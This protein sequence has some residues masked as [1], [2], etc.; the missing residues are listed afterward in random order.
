MERSKTNQENQHFFFLLHLSDPVY[1][2]RFK[3]KEREK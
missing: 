1:V 2:N 3:E